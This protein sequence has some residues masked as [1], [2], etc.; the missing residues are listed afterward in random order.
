M[1]RKGSSP[2]LLTDWKTFKCSIFKLNKKKC[3]NSNSSICEQ[4]AGRRH[5]I[6]SNSAPIWRW[7]DYKHS[8]ATFLLIYVWSGAQIQT[9]Y[10]HSMRTLSYT[11]ASKL[12]SRFRSCVSARCIYIE[13]RVS[14]REREKEFACRIYFQVF[15]F[16]RHG[17]K[18]FR[19]RNRIYGLYVY[20][21]KKIKRLIASHQNGVEK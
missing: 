20:W 8:S 18:M 7:R 4:R 19:H 3:I 10:K 1:N 9:E 2:N 15:L 13:T 14:K 21:V 17:T 16:E 5:A 12:P 6:N 11:N